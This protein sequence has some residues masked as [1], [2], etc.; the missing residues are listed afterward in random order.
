[1]S[2]VALRPQRFISA[3]TGV[4]STRN[5]RKTIVGRKLTA[6]CRSAGNSAA[7]RPVIGATMS[8]NPMM[9]KPAST[10]P[11]NFLSTLSTLIRD[12]ISGF[13]FFKV[14]FFSLKNAFGTPIISRLRIFAAGNEQKTCKIRPVRTKPPVRLGITADFIIFGVVTTLLYINRSISPNRSHPGFGAVRSFRYI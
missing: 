5:Q 7:M 13:K 2:A 14:T 11:S 6:A 1:M 8:Q 12:G 4:E 9:K 10:G 3:A